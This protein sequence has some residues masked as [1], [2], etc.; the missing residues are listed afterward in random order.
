MAA[1]QSTIGCKNRLKVVA[2]T[3]ELRW[4]G[5]GN[6]WKNYIF[7]TTRETN[8]YKQKQRAKYE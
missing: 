2:K 6:F 7:V 8:S 4:L 5:G 3:Y 1:R